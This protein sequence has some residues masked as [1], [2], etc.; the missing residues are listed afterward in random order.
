MPDAASQT[1]TDFF[2]SY[3]H[4]DVLFAVDLVRR[5]AA[6]GKRVFFDRQSLVGGDALRQKLPDAIK[7]A[8]NIVW[9]VTEAWAQSP[10]C[11]EERKWT[12]DRLG[13]TNPPRV[14]PIRLMADEPWT[15]LDLDARWKE[16][17]VYVECAPGAE[18]VTR[19]QLEKIVGHSTSNAGDFPFHLVADL[20]FRR[21]FAADHREVTESPWQQG[22]WVTPR[23]VLTLRPSGDA[24]LPRVAASNAA[25]ASPATAVWSGDRLALLEL[26]EPRRLPS[27][28]AGSEPRGWS[29]EFAP[30]AEGVSIRVLS[31]EQQVKSGT[32]IANET[33]SFSSPVDLDL[34]SPVFDCAGRCV[35]LVE[36]QDGETSWKV[37]ACDHLPGDPAFARAT[38]LGSF[39][40]LRNIILSWQHKDPDVLNWLKRHLNLASIDPL[41]RAFEDKSLADGF[42]NQLL[43]LYRTRK[44]AG[45]DIR[46]LQ[47]LIAHAVAHLPFWDGPVQQALECPNDAIDVPGV[48]APL[49]AEIIQAR[50]DRRPK[51][52]EYRGKELFGSSDWNGPV[53]APTPEDGLEQV[54]RAEEEARFLDAA[55]D[56]LDR[57]GRLGRLQTRGPLKSAEARAATLDISIQRRKARFETLRAAG[58][59]TG[60][61]A[62][63]FI[64]LAAYPGEATFAL[65]L[66]NTLRKHLPTLR[67]LFSSEGDF[68]GD[69]TSLDLIEEALAEILE[70]PGKKR[71]S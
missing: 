41:S 49:V 54:L 40:R 71:G 23:H 4:R 57:R 11:R 26:D 50:L 33:L 21:G 59:A 27:L 44:S 48:P 15:K 61:D 39:S 17:T 24:F 28:A 18:R 29:R 42:V 14:V 67:V 37:V 46:V 64:F 55:L 25:L 45:G 47:S 16:E 34:G 69:S 63:D 8:K 5:L 51:G 43:V 12:E 62:P 58:V 20:A 22:L 9:V 35:G 30:P 3:S 66:A 1:D 31:V 70:V 52:L 60:A 53:E 36:G 6:A 10:W 13:E 2:V 32:L 56:G 19:E 68:A 38:A 65:A 7:F